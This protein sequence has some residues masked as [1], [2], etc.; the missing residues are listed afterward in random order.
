MYRRGGVIR[1]LCNEMESSKDIENLS[2]KSPI[3][4]RSVIEEFNNLDSVALRNLEDWNKKVG[5][6]TSTPKLEP[7]KDENE[8]EEVEENEEKEWSPSSDSMAGDGNGATALSYDDLEER[9]DHD[10]SEEITDS[11]I[12][13]AG[14]EA[15]DDLTDY[16]NS[17]MVD[18]QA[19]VEAGREDE[20]RQC[21]VCFA[22]QE[23]DPVA[24][25]V[26]PCLCKGTT[27]WVHQVG[28]NVNLMR[29]VMFGVSGLH[30]EVGG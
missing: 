4:D 22:N 6:S 9:L 7:K 29:R 12:E 18:Y 21:W 14:S 25:W 30:T 17:D 20:E 8:D 15:M 28:R 13:T 27:K 5:S 23:D 10:Q 24:A 1:G 19:A 11:D 26:S 2:E 16:E 3:I